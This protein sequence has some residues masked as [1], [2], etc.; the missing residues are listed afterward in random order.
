M[1]ILDLHAPRPAAMSVVDEGDDVDVF[2]FIAG[3]DSGPAVACESAEVAL[4]SIDGPAHVRKRPA[5]VALACIPKRKPRIAPC[6]WLPGNP[7]DRRSE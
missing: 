5:S 7:A 3:G 6:P 4:V 2:A 1:P